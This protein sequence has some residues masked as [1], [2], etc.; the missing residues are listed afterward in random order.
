MTPSSRRSVGVF[1]GAEVE[2]VT[3]TSSAGVSV[4]VLTYGALIRDWRVPVGAERRPVTLGFDEFDHY[5]HHS[6]YFGAIAGRVANRTAGAR[7]VLDGVSY[8]LPANNGPNHLHG[9][10]RGIGK[11]NWSI[12]SH[13]DASV[14]LVLRSPDGDMG[15]PRDLDISATYTLTGH[16]L[17]IAFEARASAT[18]PVNIVQHNY[19]NLMGT[20]D[21]LDH[22]LQVAASAYMPVDEQQIPTGAILPVDGTVFDFRH[23]RTLRDGESQPLAYDHNLVLDTR[24]RPDDPV[25][26]LSAPDGSLTLRLWTDQPGLQVYNGWK[27]DLKVPGLDGRAYPRFAGI[28]L[29]DQLF[30]DALNRPYFPSPIITPDKPYRHGCAIEIA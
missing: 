7:F 23:G 9:G 19:F 10:P 14:A 27:L 18:T 26:T 24:R 5:L 1:E 20:G 13:D 11:Q 4:A 29:E 8:E 15:Y 28:C 25:A 6:P 30:P 2:E 16:R 17:E 22:R 12:A 3:L 21:V